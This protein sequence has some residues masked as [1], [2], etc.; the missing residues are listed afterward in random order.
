[1]RRGLLGRDAGYTACFVPAHLTHG[2]ISLCSYTTTN[3][4]CIVTVSWVLLRTV[5]TAPLRQTCFIVENTDTELEERHLNTIKEQFT[6]LRERLQRC[7]FIWKTH[8]ASTSLLHLGYLLSCP[9][10]GRR[11]AQKQH[12]WRPVRPILCHC[13]DNNLCFKKGQKTGVIMHYTYNWH[14]SLNL[15]LLKFQTLPQLST[16]LDQ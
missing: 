8:L 1:M 9:S 12:E 3:A 11:G 4:L 13:L 16:H 14:Y 5:S 10:P 7:H 2:E 15:F 6:A